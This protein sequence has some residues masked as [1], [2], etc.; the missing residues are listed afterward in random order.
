[1]RDD[2]IQQAVTFAV[3]DASD[4]RGATAPILRTAR[5]LYEL[6][7]RGVVAEALAARRAAREAAISAARS[8]AS[9]AREVATKAVE[10]TVA[11]L[12]AAAVGLYANTHDHLST[13]AAIGVIA[14]TAVLAL[15]ALSVSDRVEIGSA[16]RMLEAFEDD[17]QE[18]RD[19]LSADDVDSVK[20]L[21]ALRASRCDLERARRTVRTIYLGV[22]FFVL[23]GGVAFF[24]VHD[25]VGSGTGGPH[26]GSSAPEHAQSLMRSN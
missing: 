24:A 21:Q 10:R 11:L 1:M 16:V 6:A 19:A 3:R 23:A 2:S 4:F 5:S 9:T 26:S 22:T 20:K 8:A 7:S 17:A 12:I 14:T 15:V 18:L 13:G 25:H